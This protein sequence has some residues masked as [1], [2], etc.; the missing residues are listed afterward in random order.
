MEGNGGSC[1]L[2]SVFL[3][4]SN[5]DAKSL[6]EIWDAV[7]IK[8]NSVQ[9]R[10]TGDTSPRP[11]A[12]MPPGL[13]YPAVPYD[14]DVR[15]ICESLDI[16]Y[17]PWGSLWGNAAIVD[18]DPKRMLEET[19]QQIGISKQAVWYAC[20]KDF[21]GCK[22]SILCGT[23]KEETLRNTLTGLAKLDDYLE[24]SDSNRRIWA[25]CVAYIGSIVNES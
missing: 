25:A 9:N 6:S 11:E 4:L 3:G 19:A 21:A 15:S 7:T 13:P 24:G 20:V 8:P 5:V 14:R 23:T 16:T 17:V 22:S 18:H 12:K 1:S 10:F 2:Q